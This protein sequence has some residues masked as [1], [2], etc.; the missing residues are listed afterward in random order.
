MIPGASTSRSGRLAVPIL[1]G[2]AALVGAGYAFKKYKDNGAIA[3]AAPIQLAAAETPKYQNS[4][5]F[6]FSITESRLK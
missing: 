1:A 6:L 5:C 4:V 2:G 3:I